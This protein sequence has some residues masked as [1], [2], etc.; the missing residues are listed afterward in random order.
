[1]ALLR[2]YDEIGRLSASQ[3]LQIGT[4]TVQPDRSFSFDPLG[5]VLTQTDSNTGNPGSVSLT[6]QAPDLDR[7]SSV[8]YGAAPPSN[9][10]YDGAGN[11]L[12]QPTR[13][14][15]RTLTYFPNGKVKTI[16]SGG[17]NATYAYDAFGAVQQLT[18]NTPSADMRQ[19]KYFGGLVKQ[20]TEGAAS[21]VTRQIPAPGLVATRH[22]P[23]GGWTFAFGEPR[24]TRFATDQ[25]GAFVQD[26]DYQPY[27]EVKNP[28]GAPP[29]TT[30]YTSEQWNGGD[31]LAALGVVQL[32]ARIYDPVI[33]RFLS[34]D[35]II[36]ASSPYAFAANDPINRS[37]PTG[38]CPP[39]QSCP[40][41]D[42]PPQSV[43][44]EVSVPS[45]T[46]DCAPSGLERGIGSTVNTTPGGAVAGGANA[47]SSGWLG[48]AIDLWTQGQDGF[49]IPHA[50]FGA[51]ASPLA[52]AFLN[53]GAL[54]GACAASGNLNCT[55]TID[56]PK[57]RA[58]AQPYV[59]GLFE[60]GLGI[61]IGELAPSEP[62]PN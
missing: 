5:N 45:C 3:N 10:T 43:Q 9:L 60:F 1:V 11:I 37:D 49:G 28:A 7:I 18:L 14:G 12:T 48:K 58:Q 33:G 4:N 16:A 42:P 25:S 31:L 34:R 26:I 61:A 15:T 17:T 21:V 54:K 27:G 51:I 32:G 22:G 46:N 23:T 35:P 59:Q 39:E 44:P 24:G 57:N 55:K 19:D 20:R 56:T 52:D 13:S 30:N 41:N 40:D 36:S 8:A 2:G 50:V 47:G 38:L 53:A 29:G 6:Y 62:P